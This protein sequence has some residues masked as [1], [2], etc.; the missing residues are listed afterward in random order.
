MLVTSASARKAWINSLKCDS[1]KH[2]ILASMPIDVPSI[3]TL[4][5]AH[6]FNLCSSGLEH[7]THVHW[8]VTLTQ[9]P[10]FYDHKKFL[11]NKVMNEKQLYVSLCTQ[12]WR[13]ITNSPITILKPSSAMH[14]SYVH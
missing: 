12:S 13:G 6:Y 11:N 8:F 10:I 3:N 7:A 2:W 9:E 1:L 5:C 14:I 4:P